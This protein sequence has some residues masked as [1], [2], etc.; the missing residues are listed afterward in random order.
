MKKILSLTLLLNILV[1]LL[2]AQIRLTE[3]NPLTNQLDAKY[4]EMFY[5]TNSSIASEEYHLLVYT[6]DG[7]KN[8]K[9]F[10]GKLGFSSEFRTSSNET[11]ANGFTQG[12]VVIAK[13]KTSPR[14]NS[15]PA[16]AL[17]SIADILSDNWAVYEYSSGSWSTTIT[18]TVS[19]SNP[20]P[21]DGYAPNH[22]IAVM[23]FKTGTSGQPEL[24]DFV[25]DFLGTFQELI[26]FDIITFNSKNFDLS[27]LKVG[28][29]AFV[30]QS[31]G[32]NNPYQ[33]KKQG[34][35]DLPSCN[36]V[37]VK[38]PQESPGYV[39]GFLDNPISWS[40]SYFLPLKSWANIKADGALN[41]GNSIDLQNATV[42]QANSAYLTKSGTDYILRV[43]LRFI[44]FTNLV[45]INNLVTS[46][47]IDADTDNDIG[48]Y[49]KLSGNN[50]IVFQYDDPYTK[51]ALG[52]DLGPNDIGDPNRGFL[53]GTTYDQGSSGNEPLW[54]KGTDE[55]LVEL[56]I[57]ISGADAG[58]K[59]FILTGYKTPASEVTTL[60]YC[61]GTE[62][63]LQLP[64][65]LPAQFKSSSLKIVDGKAR[66][67]WTT[68]SEQ[69]NKGFEVQRSVGN[70]NDFKTIG[71]VG[72]RAKDGN[73]QTEI[74]Y[75]F[76][77]ADLKA[78]VV[79]YYRLN[80]VDFDGKAMLTP[81]KSIK[82]GS[83]ET[84]LSVYPNPNQGSFL[85]NASK[86]SGK[87]SIFLIDNT[88]RVLNHFNNVAESTTRISNLKS[89][90]YTLKIVNTET[91]EQSAQRIV[92]Q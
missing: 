53:F 76:D 45:D 68:S 71:F 13:N 27:N 31:L 59:I 2:T 65:A 75:S 78:G 23:L 33:L 83:I 88:G 62:K 55:R 19:P 32:T 35:S 22:K 66:Y 70:T 47:Y 46:V 42:I 61:F 73:S 17:T 82:P 64:A 81:I 40:V 41:A 67:S 77:D 58:K 84:D 86:L 10:V 51:D 8:P 18:P 20:D 56:K 14:F 25:A 91:G 60:D 1:L 29:N 52:N 44:N 34:R 74:N 28:Y 37:W 11:P 5:K 26:G 57:K 3:V 38:L 92:V 21:F 39:D 30:N 24:I 43:V 49:N 79:H 48:A 89:G 12:S 69:N 4:L 50:G 15:V 90:F 9:M 16:N 7:S 80:Q 72:T 85:V 87:V 63:V 6:R 36:L 54:I